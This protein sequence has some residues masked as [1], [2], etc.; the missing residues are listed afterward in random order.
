MT[1]I[2]SPIP[3]N[4]ITGF[5]GAG[6]TTAIL[7]LLAAKPADESWA[8]L[9]NEFGEV[10]SDGNLMGGAGDGVFIRAFPGGCMC[11]T[12]GLPMQ[13]ALNQ[14]IGRARPR[15][16]L[17]EPTG[18]GHPREVIDTLGAGYYRDLIDL[19]AT[20][21]LVDARNLVDGRYTG[22]D[23]FNQQ[24]AVADLI[25]ASK[26][27]L[28]DDGALTRLAAYL[29]RRELGH[30]PVVPVA[31]GAI[32]QHWLDGPRHTPAAAPMAAGGTLFS[33]GNAG[34]EPVGALRPVV[35]HREIPPCGYLRLDSAGEGLVSSGWLFEPRFTFA[36]RPLYNLLCGVEALRLK[37]V[38]ITDEG[39]VAFNGTNGVLTTL[40]L[41]DSFDSRIELIGERREPWAG[42]E[43]GLLDCLG[44][45]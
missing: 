11:C 3:T 7:A 42:L 1:L 38:F 20:L 45:G 43:Q 27:D 29:A 37:G 24:L 31:N 39:V 32:E 25:V 8:V 13:V 18:L 21:T 5:L 2:D 33:P 12:S 6:K 19:R 16:L 15:R 17:I 34:L 4:I 40:P 28:Y 35:R 9:V 23:I 44:G 41:D 26:A 36:F 10:G 14:L 30:L 22:H